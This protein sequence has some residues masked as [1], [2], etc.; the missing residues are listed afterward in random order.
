[1]SDLES[2]TGTG[3]SGLGRMSGG[4]FF[5]FSKPYLDFLGKEK[6]FSIV[7]YAMAVLNLLIPIVI[8]ITVLASNIFRYMPA[9]FT[10]AFIFSWIVVAFAC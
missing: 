3:E 10:V 5:R 1:M 7:Y 4:P 6:I 8:I 2:Q 9:K